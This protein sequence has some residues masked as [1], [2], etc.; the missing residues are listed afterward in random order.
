MSR[1]VVPDPSDENVVATPN[2]AHSQ[3]LPH[4]VTE[5]KER[6]VKKL[7]SERNAKVAKTLTGGT[8]V[9]R[10]CYHFPRRLP[11]AAIRLGLPVIILELVLSLSLPVAE[12]RAAEGCAAEGCPADVG[13]AE[14]QDSGVLL[15][16]VRCEY[17]AGETSIRVLLPD[18]CEDGKRYQVL[19]VLPVE[20]G[21]SYRWGNPLQEIQRLDLQNK[22]P[23]ICVYP[24]FS[25]WPWYAD[26]PNDPTI[27]QERYFVHVVV[28][29]IDKSYPVSPSAEG[30]LLVGFSKSGWGAF[31]LLL[32]FPSLFGRAAAWDAPLNMPAPNRFGMERI[33]GSQEN[34]ER[35]QITKLLRSAG[36][37]L[38]AHRRLIH[39]GYGNFREH[40]TAIEE[41]LEDLAIPHYYCDGPARRHAWTSGWLPK[42]IECLTDSSEENRVSGDSR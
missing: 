41:L 16:R 13:R 30:R 10:S 39:L 29:F 38:G 17:Q 18:A 8:E 5:V 1:R 34:F 40:H 7:L 20:P 21:S 37:K 15:H 28:P 26:H 25:H 27:R 42:A 36:P 24:T 31:S 35:Y 14:Q 12:S 9:S 2:L 32:R 22:H 23:L 4:T 11:T 33:F 3:M 6:G 19:Y